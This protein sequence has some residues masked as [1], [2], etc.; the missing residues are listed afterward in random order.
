M[1]NPW[2]TDG[3]WFPETYLLAVM[4]A[5]EGMQRVLREYV[6]RRAFTVAE[7]IKIVQDVLFNTSNRLYKLGLQ[8]TPIGQSISP[9]M[10]T[11]APDEEWTANLTQ[12]TTFLNKQPMTRYLRLQWL[13]YTATPRVRVLPTKQALKLFADGKFVTVP[14]VVLGLLQ[15]DYL[16]PGF[17]PTNVYDLYP[18]FESLRLGS[19]AGY[20][21][22][23]CEFRE[24]D[25]TELPTC[26]RICLRRQIEKAIVHGMDFLVG[27]EIEV[28]F[29]SKKTVDGEFHYGG[30][31]I[32]D[33]GHAWSTARA[34]QQDN[35]MD[36]L[37]VI[38]TKL[39]RAGIEL[40]QFHAESS[41]G[42][43][44]IILDPLP[45]LAAVDAL[46]AAR[47][48][49]SSAAANAYM[50][51]TLYPKPSP[52]HCGTGAHTHLSIT[53]SEAWRQ[54]YAG[55]LKHL[56]AIA[57]FTYSN[58]ASYER[59]ADGVWAGSSWIAWGTQNRE[60]PVRRVE[61]S[62]F[63]MKCMDGLSNPY[64]ALAAIIGAG[65]QGVL[66]K[67]ALSMKDCP[68]DPAKLSAEE[69]RNL[70]ITKQFPTSIDEA[71]SCLEEDEEVCEI[72]GRSVVDHYTKVKRTE[73]EKLKKMEAGKR[74]DWLMER[75]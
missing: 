22:L 59:V 11:K 70:G 6:E 46:L 18:R 71:L 8:L 38:H 55:V 32:N 4:Q 10:S 24:K 44:E 60:T 40:Q 28:V 25:G 42:Q 3:H 75:Y 19:R 66:D 68:A 69:R 67:E 21:T 53:P 9:N 48:I 5:R 13:D 74:R 1:S 20:A 30:T 49:I 16:C 36:L 64:L 14:N 33:G 41:P 51:A 43:Y 61:G 27:F 17:S 39:G 73:N 56:Q 62:H 34:L 47:E 63:E 15:D 37:E 29:M 54:F 31:P 57:A 2:R 7:A 23:Q 35:I 45:P 72:L 26:P 50:R 52:V 58:D 12:L 65:V